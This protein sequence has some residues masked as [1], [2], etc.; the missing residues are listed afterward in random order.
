MDEC[1]ETAVERTGVPRAIVDDHGRPDLHGGVKLFQQR[2]LE[3]AEVYDVKHKAACLQARGFQEQDETWQSFCSWWGRVSSRALQQTE[4][5][6]LD[7]LPV[8]V[9]RPGS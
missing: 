6:P 7:A 4:L 3:T 5:A 1:L 2:H 8:S 9:R